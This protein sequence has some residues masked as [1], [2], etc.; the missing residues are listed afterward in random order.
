MTAQL[1][2]KIFDPYGNLDYKSIDY[3]VQFR[4]VSIRNSYTKWIDTCS[5]ARSSL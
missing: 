4:R 5:V 1:N 3:E 2:Q